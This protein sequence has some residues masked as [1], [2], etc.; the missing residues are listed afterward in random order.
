MNDENKVQ[1]IHF[2]SLK[3]MMMYLLIYLIGFCSII[4]V[5][6]NLINYIPPTALGVVGMLARLYKYLLPQIFLKNKEF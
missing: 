6:G 5:E 1:A 4:T 3:K 2:V